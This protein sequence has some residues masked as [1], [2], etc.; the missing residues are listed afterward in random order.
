MEQ[1]YTDRKRILVV[2]DEPPISKVCVETLNAEGFQVD[3]AASGKVALD[4]L[5]QKDY[6]LC[7]V[8]IRTPEMDGIE[9]YGRLQKRH[10]GMVNKIVFTSGDVLGSDIRSFLESADR[11]YLA[12]P[13]YPDELRAIVKTTLGLT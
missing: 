12:K 7:L 11:P 3:V 10:P 1:A 5:N 13:F 9:L 2:E 4:M 6:D 8:D